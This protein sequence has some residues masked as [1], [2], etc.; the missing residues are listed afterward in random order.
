MTETV[1]IMMMM[2]T[3]MMMMMMMI[4]KTEPINRFVYA[5]VQPTYYVSSSPPQ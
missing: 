4:M 5:V 2:T 1:M 3:K